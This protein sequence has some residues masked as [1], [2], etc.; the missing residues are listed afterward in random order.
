[1]NKYKCKIFKNSKESVLR[2]IVLFSFLLFWSLVPSL[3]AE[4]LYSNDFNDNT[5]GPYLASEFDADWNNSFI[6]ALWKHIGNCTI[7]EGSES[8]N[9]K[10]LKVRYPAGQ[11]GGGAGAQ[12]LTKFTPH[13]EI[14][15]SYWLKFNDDFDW[16]K[17]GK[18]PGPAALDPATGNSCPNGGNRADGTNGLEAVGSWK[19]PP[20]QGALY[21]YVYH[22]DQPIQYGET[23]WWDDG[24]GGQVYGERGVWHHYEMRLV[25]NTVNEYDGILQ[26][27]Q[28]GVLVG[29]RTNYRWRT[30]DTFSVDSFFFSTHFGGGDSSYAPSKDEYAYFDNI[31]IST[32]RVGPGYQ[33][34]LLQPPKNLR[35][36]TAP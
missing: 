9:G 23:M 24:P 35:V 28:D 10:S 27:W 13:D 2:I 4:I 14:Y 25:I 22:T 5:T 16:V 8:Y 15:I 3:H 11:V 33:P 6:T 26:V 21:S 12:W 19:E 31:I 36:G 18:L 7:V 30:V 32:E 34:S 17:G 20:W 1:M 29:E